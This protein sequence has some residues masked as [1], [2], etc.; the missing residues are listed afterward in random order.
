MSPVVS[1][2]P[3]PTPNMQ[4]AELA[5]VSPEKHPPRQTDEACGETKDLFRPERTK[6]C[7]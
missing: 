3:L 7:T 6:F 4:R 2:A 1:L 5:S